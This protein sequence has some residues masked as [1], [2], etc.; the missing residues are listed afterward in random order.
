MNV[1][2]R[3]QTFAE[4]GTVCISGSVF[5]HLK[6]RLDLR[7]EGLGDQQFENIAEPVR[8]LRI[9]CAEAAFPYADFLARES[10]PLPKKPSIAIMPFANLSSDPAQHSHAPALPPVPALDGATP[11]STGSPVHPAG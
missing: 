7:C 5:A 10:L 1:A 8:T 9:S 6:N 11:C 3:L 2:A 4:P